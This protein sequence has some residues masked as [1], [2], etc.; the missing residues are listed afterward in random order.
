MRGVCHRSGRGRRGSR[1]KGAV[2]VEFAFTAPLV[3]LFLF[4]AL[5]FGRYN[6]IVQTATNAAFEAARHCI[7]PGAAASDGQTAGMG[8]LNAVGIKSATVTMNPTTITS[9]TQQVTATVQIPVGSN[10]WLAPLFVQ[11]GTLSRSCTLTCDWV[12]ST[13]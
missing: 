11:T 10:L 2:A 7:V 5:E 3:F 8:V 1:R 13:R 4:A 9:A 12:D 6:M